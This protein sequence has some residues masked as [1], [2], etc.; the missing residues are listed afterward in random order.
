MRTWSFY[1][2]ADGRFLSRRLT[3]TDRNAREINTPPGYRAIEG[4]FD[5]LSQRVDLES[6][7][8]VD[9]ADLAQANRVRMDREREHSSSLQRIEQ[10]ERQQLRPL[11]ELAVDPKN[12]EAESRLRSIDEQIAEL[13]GQL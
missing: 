1:S 12:A 4:H 10:L 9:D 3:S 2:E 5:H 8:V 7:Q 11:R 13:R 6:G